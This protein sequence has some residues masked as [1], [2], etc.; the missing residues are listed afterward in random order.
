MKI[1]FYMVFRLVYE[2]TTEVKC[3]YLPRCLLQEPVSL[4]VL[5]LQEEGQPPVSYTF[6]CDQDCLT[7]VVFTEQ[8]CL[9]TTDGG[10]VTNI[11]LVF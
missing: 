11:L 10:R 3:L 1:V 7:R 2:F 6:C 5:M 9:C 4:R 8:A